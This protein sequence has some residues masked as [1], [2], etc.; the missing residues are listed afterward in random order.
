MKKEKTAILLVNLGTP[1]SPRPKDVKK[2]LTEFLTDNRV[3][4]IPWLQRQLLVRGVIIPRRYRESAKA[5]QAIWTEEGSPLLVYTKRVASLLQERLDDTYLVRYAMRYQNPS[6]ENTLNEIQREN[7]KQIILLPLFPQHASAT[8]GSIFQKS[9]DLIRKWQI[10][11][12]IHWIPHF[13]NH[14]AFIA[15]WADRI[16]SFPL[17]NYD[18]I[19][20]S[21]HGLPIRQL[22][23]GDKAGCCKGNTLCCNTLTSENQSCYG[24]QCYATAK[25]I[26]NALSLEANRWSVTFQSRLGKEPWIEPFTSDTIKALANQ[27]MKKI[28]VVSPAFV[29][30]CLETLYEIGVELNEEFKREGGT[31]LDLVPG[32][33][34]SEKWLD[35]LEQMVKNYQ[36]PSTFHQSPPITNQTIS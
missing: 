34:D 1:D 30:D 3:I 15:A 14:P 28:L 20:F 26:A 5:Y 19:L 8:S 4:D 17:E 23:K 25:K 16:R 21:F 2:Y 18:R 33:N 32:L 6:L 27:G 11:P 12:E 10:I 22:Q 24:A 35:T 31:Q 29:C 36:I 7:C 13:Y 9:I